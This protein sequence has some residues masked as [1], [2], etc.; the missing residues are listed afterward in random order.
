VEILYYKRM[1]NVGKIIKEKYVENTD[2][3]S[4]KCPGQKTLAT[5]DDE[6]PSH[7]LEK[8]VSQIIKAE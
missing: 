1:K 5:Q 4:D 7:F 3:F 2:P 8:K 6:K